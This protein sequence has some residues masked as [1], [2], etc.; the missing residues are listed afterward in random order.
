[1]IETASPA[2]ITLA[3]LTGFVCLASGVV[4]L[5]L[6]ADRVDAVDEL[7]QAPML[8]VGA[9]F[10]AILFGAFLI[11]A[12]RSWSDPLAILVSLIGWTAFL[13]GLVLLGLP[14]LY[15][16]IARPLMRH[17][18]YLGLFALMLGAFLIA[19]GLTSRATPI[20]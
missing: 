19:A 20:N 14:R 6:P 15:V 10:G 9:A 5:F 1:M 16:R 12:Q 8:A 11:L 13:E 7:E 3:L 4:A 2:T 18:R 17:A